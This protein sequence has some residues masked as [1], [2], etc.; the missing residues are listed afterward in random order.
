MRPRAAMKHHQH[1]SQLRQRTTGPSPS[2]ETTSFRHGRLAPQVRHGARA[3][4]M[5]APKTSIRGRR[6]HC[7]HAFLCLLKPRRSPPC[8]PRSFGG[9]LLYSPTLAR[10]R[11][12]HRAAANPGLP[13]VRRFCRDG[14]TGP[15]PNFRLSPPRAGTPPSSDGGSYRSRRFRLL[16]SRAMTEPPKA[17][18]VIFAP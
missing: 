7:L 10:R 17:A 2:V 15:R 9:Q 6:S 18:A 16:T 5:S 8:V 3:R 12:S 4:S 11:N 13:A 1:A 14:G